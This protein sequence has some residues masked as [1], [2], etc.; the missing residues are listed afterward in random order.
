V[1][2]DIV[3][4]LRIAWRGLWRHPVH[5]GIALGTLTLGLTATIV[6]VSL[7][8]AIGHVSQRLPDADRWGWLFV[9]TR[10][11]RIAPVSLPI[12]DAI[13]RDASPL[14][15]VAAEG[16]VPLALDA[17]ASVD[18]V[19]AL[20]V[21]A[22]Y[23]SIVHVSPLVGR[24]LSA[25]DRSDGDVPVLVR[26]Q[27]WRR[28]MDARFDD[29]AVRLTLNGR[30]AVVVGVLPD[31]FQGPGGLFDPD[32]WV[33]L[34]ARETLRLSDR[35]ASRDEHWLTLLARPHDAVVPAALEA[36]VEAT[37]RAAN[38]QVDDDLRV[39][40]VRLSDG[41]PD[42]RA[43]ARVAFRGLLFVGL[44]FTIACFNVAGLTLT[45]AI[46][47]RRDLAVRIA[48][49]SSTWRLAKLLLLEGLILS[50]LATTTAAIAATW[51][52]W[53]LTAF[54][55]PAPIPQ[56]LHLEMSRHVAIVTVALAVMAALIPA[57]TPL[58]QLLR[59]DLTRWVRASHNA[60]T[61]DR[62]HLRTQRTFVQ[63]QVGGATAFLAA[64]LV[65]GALLVQSRRVDPG[66]DVDRL[67]TLDLDGRQL[68][69]TSDRA[70]AL[71][72]HIFDR[73]HPSSARTM[74]IANRA[75]FYVGTT[76]IHPVEIDDA[77]CDPAHCPGSGLYAVTPDFFAVMGM[78]LRAGRA[79]TDDP[80]D[81]D[82]IVVSET[83]AARFWPGHSA[84]G[85]R[86][87]DMTTGRAY[88]VVGV[89]RDVIQRQFAEPPMPYLY[90]RF[91]D[92]DYAS[93]FTIVARAAEPSALVAPMRR[94]TADFDRTLPPPPIQTMRERT[95]LPLWLPRTLAGFFGVCGAVAIVLSAV[96]LFGMIYASVSRRTREFA[97]R[98]AIGASPRDVLGQVARETLRV[99]LPGVAAGMLVAGVV[100]LV[101]RSSI[102]VIGHLTFWPILIAGALQI[103]VIAIAGLV[104]AYRASS[105]D[106]QVALRVE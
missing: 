69:Y 20:A 73:L 90:R 64:A 78:P 70:H 65:A 54:S 57:I 68:G 93:P 87:R 19:W 15:H 84:L 71:A 56:R 102:L 99:A 63:L 101:V 76:D 95:A 29:D 42:A 1:L 22:D 61:A 66:F 97:I 36:R 24:T 12:F 88:I 105:V 34:T 103:L 100:L 45:R 53:L 85:G 26:E 18:R 41:H 104:P 92:D 13:A 89:V 72:N 75:P 51:S 31:R 38:P 82:A 6:A 74:A 55:L 3:R 106:P 86:L 33:P 80:S 48:L 28:R 5:A 2:R 58:W 83:A 91:G 47:R 25:T 39:E 11:N 27:F 21:S 17:G 98:L 30:P 4:D 44:V 35:L 62:A 94:A 46:D 8:D 32:L 59:G 96:G 9:G 40:Y 50:V 49:G 77:S 81:R 10:T 16:R 60:S 43:I 52:G 37:V 23:F 7:V 67:V 14:A 79:L